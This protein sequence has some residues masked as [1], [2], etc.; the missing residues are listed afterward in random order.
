M[1]L[2]TTTTTTQTI[3]ITVLVENRE[4]RKAVPIQKVLFLF[5]FL[6]PHQII[7]RLEILQV[8]NENSYF[9][10]D[11][12]ISYLWT[13]HVDFILELPTVEE[14]CA[15]YGLNDVKIEY[16]EADHQSLTSYKTFQQHVRPIVSKENPKVVY[17]SQKM[18]THDRMILNGKNLGA[19]GEDD[20]VGRC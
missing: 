20:D 15:T 14:V 17:C 18:I 19:Y 1:I 13:F 16:E 11:A 4:N 2:C 7:L 5:L 3:L 6:L 9:R 12:S 10:E 8:I